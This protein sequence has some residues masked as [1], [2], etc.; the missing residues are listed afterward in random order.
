MSS[1][2]YE[3]VENDGVLL[4][5]IKRIEKHNAI[6]SE[7]M[8]GLEKAISYVKEH[9]HVKV[10]ALTGDGDRSFCSGGD[11]SEFHALRTEEEAFSMLNKMGMILYNLATLP[12]PTIAIVNGTAVGGGCEI[13]TACDFRLVTKK[14]RAGFIQGTLAITTGWGGASYLF[15]RGLKT[16]DAFKM[17]LEAKPLYA[18]DLLRN[19]WA[20]K[21]YEGNK[22]QA[23]D[24]FVTNMQLI[25]VD[26]HK[27]YKA[28]LLDKWKSTNLYNR[29]VNEI[30]QCAK[31]WEQDAHHKAVEA[32]LNKS[33]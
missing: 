26:V 15:E 3:I 28:I 5:T 11:L 24:D 8:E 19:G 30:N 17:L 1:M 21:L 9:E 10:F 25:H 18:D 32:F 33:K 23:L 22:L 13:A 4:F 29:V 2:A 31:L 16:D 14:A 7:V 20:S 6:N 12:I 27:A